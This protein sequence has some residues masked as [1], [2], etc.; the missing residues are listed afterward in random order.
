MNRNNQSGN[1]IMWIQMVSFIVIL[2][3]IMTIVIANDNHID[4]NQAL[5]IIHYVLSDPNAVVFGITAPSEW[6]KIYQ[7]QSNGTIVEVDCSAGRIQPLECK[8]VP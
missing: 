3:V 4:D 6:H 8:A 1:S 5:P 7:M 2:W